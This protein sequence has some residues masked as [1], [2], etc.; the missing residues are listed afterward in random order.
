MSKIRNPIILSILV[1][2]T[3]AA[4][5]YAQVTT[6]VEPPYPRFAAIGSTVAMTGDA[7]IAFFNP[8]GLSNISKPSMDF[9]F[10]R[11]YDQNFMA[12]Y[13]AAG[14][15]PLCWHQPSTRR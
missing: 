10:T 4:T 8:A 9:A 11:P 15:M 13:G 1:I 12:V 5:S 6:D 2:A 14:A 3:F 7:G